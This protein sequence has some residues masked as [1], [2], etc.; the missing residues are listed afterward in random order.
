MKAGHH[1]RTCIAYDKETKQRKKIGDGLIEKIEREEWQKHMNWA[2]IVLT[3]DN[4]KWLMTLDAYRRKGYPVF[5]PSYESAQLELD[6]AKGQAFLKANGVQTMDYEVFT[7]YRKAEEFVKETGK[8]YV[9]KP[10]GDKDKALTYCAK[11]AADMCYMLERWDANPKHAGTKF[12]LQ[13]FVPGIE[14]AVNGWMGKNGF[15]KY[16]EESFEHKKLCNDDKGPSTGEQ[17]TAIKYV[18]KSEL[19]DEILLPL[20]RALMKIG[21][22]GSIDVSAIIDEDGVPQ[23]LEFTSRP[24]W[25]AF[26]I[27]Q[28]LHPDPIEWM[29][30][31]LD[32]RDTFRPYTDHAIGVVMTIPDYP[33]SQF[34][35]K[36]VSGVPVYGLDDANEHRAELAP[37]ELMDGKAPAMVD[38]KVEEKRLMVSCG[39]YLVVA[40]GVGENVREAKKAAYAA[41]E[42]VEIP[43]NVIYRTDI[44]DRLRTQLPKLQEYGFATDWRY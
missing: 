13:E 39:D 44:G 38:G 29:A 6:R 33:Y 28:E 41:A 18:Q 34:T 35:K 7:N 36:E 5:A 23:P 19:A 37:C 3:S 26:N 14:F 8:R 9:S 12:M 15:A 27:V 2:D 11:N 42:S 16:I 43:N 24:G 30:D 22:T 25:P 17:G 21:H 32:G 40:T 20:E 31:L 10:F 1:V 4:V